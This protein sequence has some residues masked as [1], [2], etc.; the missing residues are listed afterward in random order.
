MSLGS[1]Q[2]W[3][4][5][6]FNECCTNSLLCS[7]DHLFFHCSYRYKCNRLAYTILVASR[8]V[9]IDMETQPIELPSLLICSKER[10]DTDDDRQDH[11][12]TNSHI[13]LAGALQ[14][15]AGKK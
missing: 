14:I 9:H 4:G 11:V 15:D 6:R 10:T 13:C 7:L 3:S 8:S 2:A 12:N 1:H 5:A